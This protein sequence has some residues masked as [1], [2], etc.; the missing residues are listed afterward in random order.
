MYSLNDGETVWARDL[1]FG[2]PKAERVICDLV[3][4]IWDLTHFILYMNIRINFVT[5]IWDIPRG[6]GLWLAIDFTY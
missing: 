5:Y 4:V 2:P 3:L 1:S 6:T